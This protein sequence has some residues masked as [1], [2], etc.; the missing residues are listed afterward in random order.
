MAPKGKSERI[1]LPI[2]WT[3]HLRP[4]LLRHLRFE[5]GRRGWARGT[6][7]MTFVSGV[8]NPK[9]MLGMLV[10]VLRGDSIATRRRL[11]RK[12]NV[13]FEDLMRG[14]SDFDVRSV[15]I[16]GSGLGAVSVADYGR[17]CYRYCDHTVGRFVLVS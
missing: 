2:F 6:V 17:D 15:T 16:E 1:R 12:G 8:H 14:T 4:V 3:N 7:L 13:T 11:A 9:I 10:E 5:I